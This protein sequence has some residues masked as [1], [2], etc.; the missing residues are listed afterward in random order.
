MSHE[1]IAFQSAGVELRGTLSIPAADGPVSAIVTV[2]GAT[3]WS[4][5][6]RLFT[7]LEALVAPL[8][9][10]TLR[11]DRRG[12]GESGGDFGSADFRLLA[13]ALRRAGF[14]PATIDGMLALRRRR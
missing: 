2:H 1:P 12:S 11:Y 8:P 5:D 13:T 9:M 3:G 14:P 4:R 10:A 7:H 6:V